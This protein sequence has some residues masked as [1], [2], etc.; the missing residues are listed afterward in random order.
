MV[1]HVCERSTGE[2]CQVP[3]Q[4]P[5]SLFCLTHDKFLEL[6]DIVREATD[7]DGNLHL[8]QGMSADATGVPSSPIELMILSSALQYLGRGWTFDNVEEATA[9]SVM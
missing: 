3:L 9:I 5:P 7:D 2:Q 8:Q 1:P 4:I 6:V